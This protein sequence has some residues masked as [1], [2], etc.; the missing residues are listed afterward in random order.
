VV[1]KVRDLGAAAL[2]RKRIRRDLNPP[3]KMK[4]SS[5]EN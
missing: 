4:A 1:L 5:N 3:D 2:T